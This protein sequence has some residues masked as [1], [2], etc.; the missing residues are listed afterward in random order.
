[1]QPYRVIWICQT[2]NTRGK[3]YCPD[4]KQIPEDILYDKCCE[5]LEIDEFDTE[6]FQ[7][8]IKQIIVPEPNLLTF[9][10]KDGREQTVHWQD[11]SRSEAWTPEKRVKAAEH[12]KK[13]WK[14]S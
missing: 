5:V 13:R 8:E 6:I 14:K 3:K 10:F 1:M 9:I 2:Y 4:S 7:C 12:S 11:H